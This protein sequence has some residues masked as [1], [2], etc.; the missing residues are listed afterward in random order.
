MVINP[1]AYT[2]VTTTTVDPYGY[3]VSLAQNQQQRNLNGAFT[4]AELMEIYRQMQ[5]IRP[6]PPVIPPATPVP[7]AAGYDAIIDAQ[8][9]RIKELSAEVAY[10]SGVVSG[11]KEKI[12]EHWAEVV[13]Q[14]QE[15]EA[16]H[17]F[18]MTAETRALEMKAAYEHDARV[19]KESYEDLAERA[20]QKAKIMRQALYRIV[21]ASQGDG[22]V[23]DTAQ[24]ARSALVAIG[25]PI[26]Q[27]K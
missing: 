26:D 10:L 25:F 23:V 5:A 24:E 27:R 11:Q 8:A 16:L 9:K 21:R 19:A 14:H 22:W 17:E 1:F 3:A 7:D 6:L 2:A 4:T 18:K 12:A 20:D 13:S 15:L